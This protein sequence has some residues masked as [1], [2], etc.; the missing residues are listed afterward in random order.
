MTATQSAF[1]GS[2]R[3][4][5]GGVVFMD[6]ATG[7]VQRII[8]MQYNPDS[9]SRTLQPQ[10]TGDGAERSEALR[11]KGPPVETIKLEAEI[12]ATD[13]IGAAE[14]DAIA[15]QFGILPQLAALESMAYPPSDRLQANND[16]ARRGKLEIIPVESPL[17]LLV[18][19]SN[20]VMPVRLTDYSVTEEAF[21]ANLNPI[22]AK[23]N[24]GFR[25]LSVNDLG[26][27]HRG[28]NLYLRYQKSRERL[29]RQSQS[30]SFSALGISGVS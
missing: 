23:V 13:Q 9:L 24:L 26:F 8:V 25:V 27:D 20:R 7:A 18:W 29:A 4:L 22:R 10:G 28:G 12:D 3:L 5:K 11:L 15:T 2:P 21:D 30:G 19:S 1:P 17:T 16:L 6:A 14:P